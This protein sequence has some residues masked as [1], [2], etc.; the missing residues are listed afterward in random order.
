MVV[1]HWSKNALSLNLYLLTYPL[2]PQWDIRPQQCFDTRLNLCGEP[3]RAPRPTTRRY[4][5]TKRLYGMI[6]EPGTLRRPVG[7]AVAVLSAVTR[8]FIKIL[9]IS[10]CATSTRKYFNVPHWPVIISSICRCAWPSV[11]GAFY[12]SRVL[13]QSCR[14]LRKF[15]VLVIDVPLEYWLVL[16][17][18][19]T[20]MNDT[21]AAYLH[22]GDIVSLYAEGSVSG[23]LSTLG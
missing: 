10:L 8:L 17:L 14:L 2:R 11:G 23:F 15:S 13:F 9:S 22:M 6:R 18:Q 20:D 16:N 21:P 3:K 12:A 4:S 19:T 5:T 1:T 7:V